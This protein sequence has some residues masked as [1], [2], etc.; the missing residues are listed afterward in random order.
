[1]EVGF[2]IELADSVGLAVG[3]KAALEEGLLALG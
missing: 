3:A 2:L 1:M